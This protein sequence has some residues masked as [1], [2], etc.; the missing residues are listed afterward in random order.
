MTYAQLYRIVDL[1]NVVPNTIDEEGKESRFL[2]M[3]QVLSKHF[4]THNGTFPLFAK[5][6]QKQSGL[7]V[8][9]VVPNVKEV[10]VMI[11]SM[12]CQL[13]AFIKHY[14]LQKGL[15][16]GFIV[17]LV[18]ATCCL[19]LVGDINTVTWDDKKMELITPEDAKDKN[20]LSA[21][22]N[23]PW[24]FNIKKLRVSPTKSKKNYT[25]PE[26]LL[27]LNADCSII[28]LQAKNDAKRAA[29]RYGQSNSD[30]EE[31]GLDSASNEH[32]LYKSLNDKTAE[33]EKE[34][35]H[36]SISWSHSGSSDER[37]ASQEAAGSG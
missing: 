5:V 23:T 30:S 27:N 12:N 31:E 3:W 21:F 15:D 9:A 13:P 2:C 37:L 17:R 8:E 4:R 26:A 35:G 11:G 28:T 32:K 10:D 36:K 20:Q 24:Y 18:V 25:A 29:D 22:A 33:K 1:D 16:Q 14:L 34:P 7:P 6:H 19:T